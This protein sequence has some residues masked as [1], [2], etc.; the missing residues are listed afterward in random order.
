LVIL[1]YFKSINKTD[2]FGSG[3]GISETH[4]S[5]RALLQYLQ[6]A[7]Y[8]V[9]LLQSDSKKGRFFRAGLDLFS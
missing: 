2:N 7:R 9:H 8:P 4:M 1:E 3:I 6:L 5:Q